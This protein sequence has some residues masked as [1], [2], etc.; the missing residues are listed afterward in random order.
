MRRALI[1]VIVLATAASA[2]GQQGFSLHLGD[3]TTARMNPRT[4]ARLAEWNSP[5]GRLMYDLA[6]QR[7]SLGREG[8]P[9][10]SVGVAVRLRAQQGVPLRVVTAA[11]ENG[12]QLDERAVPVVHWPWEEQT[13]EPA[14]SLDQQISLL[15]GRR[16]EVH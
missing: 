6:E 9:G 7:A 10:S 16:L 3:L 12:I 14:L 5:M 1:L 13:Q 4:R 15:L 8:L 11:V 2:M